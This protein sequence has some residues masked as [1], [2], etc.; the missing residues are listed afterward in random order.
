MAGNENPSELRA[1]RLAKLEAIR[2]AGIDPY[3]REAFSKQDITEV[4]KLAPE[5]PA[6]I[7]GRI[8]LFRDMG[9]IAFFHI[10]DRSGRM[11]VVL[12][13]RSFP[14]DYKFWVKKLDMGDIVHVKGTRYNTEKGEPSILADAIALVSKALLPLPE[15]W[16]GMSD[17]EQIYRQR[18]LDLVTN[19]ESFER[20]VKRS[21]IVQGLREY[22]TKQGFLEV[23][24]PMMQAEAGGAAATPFVTHYN[25]LDKD[26]VFRIATELHL[27]RMLVGGF[28]K[29][30]EIG[31]NF[32]NEGIDRKHS[33]EYT[34]LE[35]YQAY[36][37]YK[38]MEELLQGMI[39]YLCENIFHKWT[40]Q[41]PER[42]EIIDFSKPWAEVDYKDLVCERIGDPNWFSL[43]RE[44]H[45]AKLK[46]MGLEV[47][48][49]WQ[50]YEMTNEF[51]SKRIEPTLIQPT[52]VTHMPLETCPLAKVNKSDPT[53]IDVFECVFAGMEMA[54]AYSEQNDPQIQRKAFLAQVGEETQRFDEDFITALE[55]GMPS[56]GGM[57]M[58][59]D[60]LIMLLTGTANI[61]DVI[62][63]PMLKSQAK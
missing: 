25:A 57:G 53:T 4:L 35:V 38:G 41:V 14:G 18:Y 61:R 6:E 43:S 29:V 31:K 12:N 59:I 33:P 21:Q 3:P 7:A 16:A 8:M 1:Q 22:L 50:D 52:F 39:S 36:S 24:T 60:R 42:D 47:R 55:Q 13:K 26:V 62:L 15:K 17:P 40:F 19:R 49:D 27:K 30:F 34:A 54:P 37:N 20:F 9:N 28:E 63:F 2:T 46:E 10:Q 44:D 5:A 58:G 11:Q 23:E 56:A 48:P 45:F 32:R 51:Y